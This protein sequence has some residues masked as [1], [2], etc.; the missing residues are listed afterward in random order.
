MIG[1]GKEAG[2][3]EAGDAG[4]EGEANVADGC[5]QGPVEG[6]HDARHRAGRAE[7]DPGAGRD[8]RCAPS[9]NGLPARSKFWQTDPGG[10]ETEIQAEKSRGSCQTGEGEPSTCEGWFAQPKTECRC[11]MSC[12]HTDTEADSVFRQNR[13]PAYTRLCRPAGANSGVVGP[14][15]LAVW[16]VQGGKSGQATLHSP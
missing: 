13:P 15:L 7:T 9:P 10:L 14:C 1:P 11:W 16:N 2:A 5:L 4:D 12:R 6:A 8:G 3:R